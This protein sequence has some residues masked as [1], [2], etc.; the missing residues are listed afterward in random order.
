MKKRHQIQ[1]PKAYRGY[2]I[3]SKS[4]PKKSKKQ[5]NK[6]PQECCTLVVVKERRGSQYSDKVACF[7]HER[8]FLK[9]LS[10]NTCKALLLIEILAFS[11]HYIGIYDTI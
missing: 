5:P 8:S 6:K 1:C 3:S 9:G 10:V 4:D 2:T 11:Y 7:V